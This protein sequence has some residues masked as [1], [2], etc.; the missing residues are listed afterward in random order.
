MSS[1]RMSSLTGG[2]LEGIDSDLCG[3]VRV[4]PFGGTS[5][6]LSTYVYTGAQKCHELRDEYQYE[7]VVLRISP[8]MTDTQYFRIKQARIKARILLELVVSAI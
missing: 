3:E 7:M 6:R 1:G 5:I 8:S 2:L 4:G